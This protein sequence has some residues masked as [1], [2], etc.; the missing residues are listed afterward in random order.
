VVE[1]VFLRGFCDF[2]GVFW[3]V[4]RG[5]VVVKCVVNVVTKTPLFAAL[6]IC[7]VLNFIFSGAFLRL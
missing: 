2:H 5:E 1:W 3:M 6:K 7:H 4:K